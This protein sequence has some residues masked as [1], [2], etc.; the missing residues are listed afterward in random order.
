MGSRL[1]S[2]NFQQEIGDWGDWKLTSC[3]PP[4]C[5]APWQWRRGGGDSG[6]QEMK[7]DAAFLLFRFRS[8]LPRLSPP[9]P[10]CSLAGRAGM[11]RA[12][13][14]RTRRRGRP[15]DK[16]KHP[17]RFY[18]HARRTRSGQLSCWFKIVGTS[19]CFRCVGGNCATP[20]SSLC[21]IRRCWCSLVA[22]PS[23]SGPCLFI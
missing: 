21:C 19:I 5:S 9:A 23:S 16:H 14:T 15:T 18:S 17:V 4:S 12:G 8:G 10:S 20:T 7:P 22:P 13:P 11:G 1:D 6:G 3:R 2:T